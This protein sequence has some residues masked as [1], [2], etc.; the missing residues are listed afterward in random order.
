MFTQPAQRL[1]NILL[2]FEH[3]TKEDGRLH[4]LDGPVC[5]GIQRGFSVIEPLERFLFEG[6]LHLPMFLDLAEADLA[7]EADDG[8]LRHVQLLTAPLRE[9]EQ[10]SQAHIRWDI[11]P[12]RLA[13]DLIDPLEILLLPRLM[14][15]FVGA[16]IG[17]TERLCK[18]AHTWK[19][20]VQDASG[21]QSLQLLRLFR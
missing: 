5:Y 4:S 15:L 20:L 7:A 21:E 8:A 10:N 3:L 13:F 11:G 6:L 17:A 1:L 16:A 19:L 14:L 18:R 9:R 2:G 12:H